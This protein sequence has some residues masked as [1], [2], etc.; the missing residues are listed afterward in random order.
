[1]VVCERPAPR[2]NNVFADWKRAVV[3]SLEDSRA[4]GLSFDWAWRRAMHEHPPKGMD[5]GAI[6]PTLQ[7]EIPTVEFFRTACRDA[8]G[9]LMS[10][11]VDLPMAL[12]SIGDRPALKRRGRGSLI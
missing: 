3:A 8:W 7:D 11:L 9:G 10:P 4:R 2:R 6:V 5:C 1:M 12:E